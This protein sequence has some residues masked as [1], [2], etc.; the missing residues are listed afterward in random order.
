MSLFTQMLKRCVLPNYM[1]GIKLANIN[2]KMTNT[3]AV[4]DSCVAGIKLANFN[5]SA[6]ADSDP[7]VEEETGRNNKFTALAVGA[8][9]VTLS[10]SDEDDPESDLL[11]NVA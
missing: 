11:F 10:S 8:G 7:T 6:V 5:T 1:A 9:A 4:A 2:I 3:S